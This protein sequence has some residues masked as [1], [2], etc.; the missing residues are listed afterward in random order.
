MLWV[1]RRAL[2]A[3][4]PH[5]NCSDFRGPDEERLL[6]GRWSQWIAMPRGS[7]AFSASCAAGKFTVGRR[8]SSKSRAQMAQTLSQLSPGRRLALG[9]LIFT[10]ASI[11]YRYALR[12]SFETTDRAR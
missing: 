2:F 12:V 4:D 7:R 6:A 3:G 5:Y 10:D 1:G 9:G 11:G 8:N